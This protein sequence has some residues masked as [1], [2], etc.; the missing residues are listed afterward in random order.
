MQRT[1]VIK[2]ETNS[3]D[4]LYFIKR[5]IE[6]ELSCCS[7]YFDSIKIR[8]ECSGDCDQCYW[9][10]VVPGTDER[11]DREPAYYCRLFDDI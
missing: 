7:T 5:D 10:T 6:Q 4:S 2:V 8:E 9:K 1:I 11:I 3:E